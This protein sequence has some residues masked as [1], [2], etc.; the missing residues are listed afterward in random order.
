M[1]VHPPPCRLL[2]S[3]L[4]PQREI[5]DWDRLSFAPDCR[6]GGSRQVGL[7]A[8]PRGLGQLEETEGE[9]VGAWE[10]E[11]EEERGGL[12]V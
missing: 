5:H 12:G 6:V 11:V 10:G 2:H 8:A 4:G 3:P 9:R 7:V 1:G